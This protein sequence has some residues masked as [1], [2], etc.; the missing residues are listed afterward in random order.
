MVAQPLSWSLS[1]STVNGAF[2]HAP[3]C[4]FLSPLIECASLRAFVVRW[5]DF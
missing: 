4:G 1:T 5:T 3:P 2:P